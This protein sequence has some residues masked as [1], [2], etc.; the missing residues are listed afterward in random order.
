MA[1][2]KTNAR[3]L[4]VV[5][6]VTTCRSVLTEDLVRAGCRLA[7]GVESL[8]EALK[9]AEHLAPSK[10]VVDCTALRA[11]WLD[12]LGEL[13]QVSPDAA[14]VVLGEEDDIAYETEISQRGGCTY[15]SK[16]EP[17]PRLISSLC[18]CE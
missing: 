4:L 13:Q 18:P 10:I 12:V 11:R 15:R 3:P 6:P 9:A 17:L 14:I 7:L 2:P 1:K 8:D 16:L 5:S